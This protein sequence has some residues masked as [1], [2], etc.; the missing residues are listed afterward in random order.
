MYGCLYVKNTNKLHEF[1]AGRL[2]SLSVDS[3]YDE[4]TRISNNEFFY[5]ERQ[6]IVISVN[7]CCLYIILKPN[8]LKI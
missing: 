6:I 5:A 7:S 3:Q 2:L 8:V 1:P 4:F